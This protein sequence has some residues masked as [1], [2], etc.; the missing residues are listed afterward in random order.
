M[1]KF[2][3]INYLDAKNVI[4]DFA[5]STK[6][7]AITRLVD[8]LVKN[9]VVAD[10][11]GFLATVFEREELGSTGI[12][13][14]VAMPHGKS[15][16]VKRMTVALAKLAAPI[17]FESIDKKPVDFIFMIASPMNADS[18]YIKTMAAIIRSVKMNNIC[19]KMQ[20][21]SSA[22]DIYDMLV[23]ECQTV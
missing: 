15:D 16:G 21:L 19:L 12:G 13:E 18:L 10:G 3:W 14:R 5:A 9:G 6:D 17:D 4:T 7:D 1:E 2:N 11:P 22:A 8:S 23:K 20:H